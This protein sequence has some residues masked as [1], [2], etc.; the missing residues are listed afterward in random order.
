MKDIFDT[1][2]YLEENFE[3]HEFKH[4]LKELKIDVIIQDDAIKEKVRRYM[5]SV[6]SFFL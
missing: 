6:R 4:T 5:Y 1:K 3:K 2:K